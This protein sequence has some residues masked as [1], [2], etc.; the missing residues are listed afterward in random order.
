MKKYPFKFLD[1]YTRD[2]KD[3]YFGREEESEQLYEMAF[4]TNILLIFGPVGTGK[5]SLIQ[6]GLA[7]RFETHDWLALSVRRNKNLNESLWTVLAKAAK[8]TSGKDILY[9]KEHIADPAGLEKLFKSIYLNTFKPLYLIFDQFEELYI[10]GNKAD[11]EEKLFINA[12]REILRSAYPVKM[13]FSIREEYLGHLVHFEKEVPELFHKKLRVEPMGLRKVKEVI[14]NATAA[15]HSNVSLKAG[16]EHE[17]CSAIFD[18]VKIQDRV[19]TIQLPYLQ[20][21]LDKLYNEVKDKVPVVSDV[22]FSLE[23]IWQMGNMKDVL[24]GLVRSGGLCRSP[25][26]GQPGARRPQRARP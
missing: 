6:C 18:K 25:A 13:I 17:I 4:Q 14:M 24:R 7:Q 12:V 11:N 22:T 10:L 8:D 16:E 5:T 3:I 15:P 20:V 9:D 2:D 1:S 23:A 21:F 26:G 19:L